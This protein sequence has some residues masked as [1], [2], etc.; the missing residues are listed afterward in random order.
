MSVRDA[1]DIVRTMM[2]AIAA[3]AIAVIFGLSAA[4][5]VRVLS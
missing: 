4:E 3:L 1:P 2:L 5:L